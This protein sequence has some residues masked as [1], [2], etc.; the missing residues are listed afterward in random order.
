MKKANYKLYHIIINIPLIITISMILL[1][2]SFD[3][4]RGLEHIGRLFMLISFFI[5]FSYLLFM[6]KVYIDKTHLFFILIY[7]FVMFVSAATSGFIQVAHLIFFPL[8]IYIYPNI[9]KDKGMIIITKLFL[10][11]HIILIVIPLFLGI[12]NSV[13]Q[14]IY[15]GLFYNPNI[16]GQVLATLA[17][18]IIAV[19]LG[20]L[21]FIVKKRDYRRVYILIIQFCMI[22]L[23]L[24][25]VFYSQSR[26]SF[27]AIVI[28]IFLVSLIVCFPIIK[29]KK[30]KFKKK[31]IKLLKF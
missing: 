24:I 1:A 22:I 12:N 17:S 6:N 14:S 3:L 4:I 15:S 10:I 11:T 2:G 13:Y 28:N 18:I 16:F 30:I 25:G 20:E 21:T 29:N 19:F 26:T 8:L 9:C 31:I 5:S 23:S 7:G 27:L